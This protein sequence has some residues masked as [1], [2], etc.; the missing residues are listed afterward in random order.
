[1][2]IINPATEAV[3]KEVQE[4]SAASI[5]QKF[6]AAK[7]AQKAWAKVPLKNRIACLAK[8]NELMLANADKIAADLSAEVGKPVGQAKG[9][10]NGGIGRS[11]FFVENSEKYLA[12]EWMVSEGA[13]REK[14]VYEPLGIIAN[15]SAWNYPI[16]VGVNV[17]VPALI[18]GNAVLYKPSEFSTLTGLNMAE[19]LW[20]AGVPKDVFHVVV[21]GK[22]AGEALLNLPLNGYFFTGSYNT[23]RYIAER[24][25]SKLVPVGLELGGKDP[26]YVCD[27]VE[28]KSAAAAGVEGAFYNN[29]QS[30]CAVERIYVQENIYD[31]YVDAFIAEAKTMKLGEPGDEGT[32][33]GPLTR[34]QQMAVLEDQVADAVSK[35]AKLLLGG[36]KADRNG[37]YF[38][39]TVLTDVNHGMKVM[40]DESFGPIIGIQKVKDDAE[41]IS[42]ML[43]TPYGLTS[44]VYTLDADRA[45]AIMEEMNSGT[46]YWN[47][48][49]R[50]SP[51]VP[52]SGRGNS[53]LGSTLSH[54]GIRAFVQPKAYHL[55][56]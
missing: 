38:E 44:A 21:G 43:D 9:E 46:V 45:D 35:G 27:D 20:Q 11:K 34:P 13:T 10:I 28:V 15:I 22:D 54:A 30:C 26:M 4:D 36:K 31:D 2:K 24:V 8:F 18:G 51:H 14:I 3:I 5:Q 40:M 25:A 37:Y 41:A 52:W 1:M 55:R 32:F 16:L 7:T 19:M 56:G 53:G 50:V 33:I 17:F 47:C 48:C 29:G 42:L 49:D 39:P 6:E 12:E 23:G